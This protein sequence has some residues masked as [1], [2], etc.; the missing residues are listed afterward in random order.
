MPLR[1]RLH[2]RLWLQADIPM[3]RNNVRYTPNNG[4]NRVWRGMSAVDPQR[5]LAAIVNGP[6]ERADVQGSRVTQ[7]DQRLSTSAWVPPTMVMNLHS[8]LPS[9]S[10]RFGDQKPGQ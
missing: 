1:R 4:L 7:R 8:D 9:S 6:L 3:A 2:V 10:S 5:T